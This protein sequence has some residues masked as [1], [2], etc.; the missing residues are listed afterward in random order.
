MRKYLYL[1]NHENISKNEYFSDLKIDIGR[2]TRI[3]ETKLYEYSRIDRFSRV[4]NSEIGWHSYAGQCCFIR[5]SEIESFSSI[6][7]G[8]TIGAANH[9]YRNLSQHNFIYNKYD[10]L[11]DNAAQYERNI[12]KTHLGHD[13][14]VGADSVIISGV[15]MKIGSILA[16]NSTLTKDTEPFGIYSGNPASLMK[17][18]FSDEQIVK[19]KNL[20]WWDW[21]DEKIRKNLNLFIEPFDEL[22]I[23]IK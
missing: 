11:N 20:H 13:T 7:W 5:N 1:N 2:F 17:F 4:Y 16:A 9:N 6:S 18:R 15:N 3:Q 22:E 23:N 14:W 19:I 10:E 12:P 21:S 8:C